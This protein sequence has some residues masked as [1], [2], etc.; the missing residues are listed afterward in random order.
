MARSPALGDAHEITLASA[1]L[2]YRECGEGWSRLVSRSRMRST[3]EQPA[4]RP[5]TACGCYRA[6]SIPGKC[7]EHGSPLWSPQLATSDAS[8]S[9][10]VIEHREDVGAAPLALEHLVFDQVR[11]AA[12]SEPGHQTRG[13]LVSSTASS[14]TVVARTDTERSPG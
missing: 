10:L 12:H 6:C 14:R 4:P 2:R 5:K 7:H 11:L 8:I 1:T 9:P 3:G 13:W